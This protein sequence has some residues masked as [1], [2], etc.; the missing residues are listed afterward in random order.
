LDAVLRRSAVKEGVVVDQCLYSLL[1]S[2]V[3]VG[4]MRPEDGLPRREMD[5]A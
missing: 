4:A 1:L 2:E 3:S 5:K